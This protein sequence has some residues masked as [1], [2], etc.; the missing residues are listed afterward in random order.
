MNSSLTQNRERI[1]WWLIFSTLGVL[2]AFILYSYLGTFVLGLFIYYAT[3]PVYQRL[4]HRVR[5]RS[6][7]AAVALGA[8]SLPG[9]LLIVYTVLV[10]IQQLSSLVGAD[11]RQYQALLGPYLKRLSGS[12][13]AQGVFQRFLSNPQQLT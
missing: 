9:L 2:F 4:S 12:Q 10:S 3:R 13:N 11:L 6:L 1:A 5:P 7:A 8:I